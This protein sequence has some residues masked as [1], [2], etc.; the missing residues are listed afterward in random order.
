[1]NLNRTGAVV[2]V[3]NFG[4]GNLGNVQR[5]LVRLKIEHGLLERP[6]GT[7]RLGASLLLL[8]GV[9]AFRPAMANLSS[10]GWKDALADWAKRGKPLLGICLGMQLLC[11]SS[12]EG[13]AAEGLGLLK[14]DARKLTGVKKIPHMGWNVAKPC[15]EK[16]FPASCMNEGQNFYF[17]HSFAVS[18]SSHCAA[19]TD[20]DS[21]LFCSILRNKN[22]AGFQFHPERSGPEGV[23]F[24]G[25]AVNYFNEKYG[26]R[27]PC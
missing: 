9:G 6:D 25:R 16:D 5:A 4:A 13:G 1:M 11:E 17:V 2:G 21:V 22:V 8:P 14:G 19:L 10:S 24:L 7:E 3:I 15:S 20:V 12:D 18:G 27:A 26:G 23:E